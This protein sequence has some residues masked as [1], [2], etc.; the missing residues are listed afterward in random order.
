VADYFV[1][2]KCRD[3]TG[4]A[5]LFLDL[6]EHECV[7]SNACHK[8]DTPSGL[9]QRF[10]ARKVLGSD[11]DRNTGS[12]DQGFRSISQSPWVHFGIVCWLDHYSSLT[13]SSSSCIL[14]RNQYTVYECSV[15]T[16]SV[17][18]WPLPLRKKTSS[19]CSTNV[20]H[21]MKLSA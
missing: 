18:N 19:L 7:V 2:M 1:N 9:A 10:S 3:L 11:L 16:V 8:T 4:H 6:C 20:S 14:R 12:Y 21:K 5:C 13:V 17:V 15:A